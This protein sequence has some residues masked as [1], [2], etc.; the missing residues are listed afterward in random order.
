MPSHDPSSPTCPLPLAGIRVIEFSHMVMGP[1]C[2][3]I[4]ADLGADVIKIE[5][6]PAGDNTRRLTG[7]A[8]GFFPT[9]NRNKRSLCVD[10]KRPAGLALV[11]KL[12]S[13]AD[14]LIEN[15]RPGAMDKLGLGPAAMAEA[16][17]RLVYCSCK[18]FLPGPYEHRTALD[19]V[20]QMMAGLAYMTGPPGKPLRAGSSVNDIMGG[21]FAA[22]AIMASLRERERT[23]R[24]GQV[25]SGLF[26]TCMVLVGQ[27][28]ANA[29]VDGRNPPTYGDP[30]KIRPWPVYDIFESSD[31]EQQ[32]F[33]GVVTETQW[34]QFCES[35][36]LMH[37]LNDPGLQTPKQRAD[38]RPRI[39]PH[40][41]DA[42]RKLSKAELMA[43]CEALGLPFAPIAKPADLF[44]DPH[45][46]AS[47]GLLQTDLT[48]AEAAAGGRA[49][50]PVA[51][52]PALPISLVGG[53]PGLRRQPPRVGE[54][55]AEIAREAGISET[56]IAALMAEGTLSVPLQAVAAE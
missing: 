52:L 7:P 3:M 55:G 4:L 25:Q 49:H 36:D 26:E 53:R 39:L 34:R 43:R 23:G 10:L 42:F 31:P 40:V 24:G 47:G 33:V 30:A 14:A 54:H 16:N 17:P 28:M 5:P 38:E 27:H 35:F 22:I 21:M 46:L 9:F 6:A 11:K 45:L 41:Q 29:A 56:D 18:G 19:E 44:D 20:V 50:T 48:G 13:T 8:L 1:S 32:V 2:G 37:L 51:G 15:F 12:A